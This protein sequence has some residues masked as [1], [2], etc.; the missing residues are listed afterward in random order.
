MSNPIDAIKKL[1]DAGASLASVATKLMDDGW[2]HKAEPVSLM[3][4][5]GILVWDYVLWND[6]YFYSFE[7]REKYVLFSHVSDKEVNK[8][9]NELAKKHGENT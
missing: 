3:G 2:V 8:K 7:R 4:E 9:F 5:K 6:I 1:V